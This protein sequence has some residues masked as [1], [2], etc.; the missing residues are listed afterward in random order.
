MYGILC[1]L[2]TSCQSISGKNQPNNNSST[3]Y[4]PIWL[5]VVVVV[6]DVVNII[7]VVVVAV[8]N[9][10]TG[11]ESECCCHWVTNHSTNIS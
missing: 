6:D 11:N 9:Y 5:P 3:S 8:T 1:N 2:K 4:T 7:S 10:I